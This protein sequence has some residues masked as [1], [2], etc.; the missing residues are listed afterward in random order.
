[1]SS[2]GLFQPPLDR[3]SLCDHCYVRGGAGEVFF[4]FRG[5]SLLLLVVVLVLALVSSGRGDAFLR[6][7]GGLGGLVLLTR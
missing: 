6:G 5:L 4:R 3:M 7:L 2:G 1:M